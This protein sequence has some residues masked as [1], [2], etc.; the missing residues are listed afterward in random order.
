MVEGIYLL[1]HSD[2]EGPANI[3]CPQYVSIAELVQIDV[4]TSGKTI[5]VRFIKG[6][7]GV[8]AHNFSNGGI[9]PTGWQA[10]YSL[11]DGIGITHPWI[12]KQEERLRGIIT[13]HSS[14][15]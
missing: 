6:P 3:G 5:H 9:Y 11:K 4:E 13:G 15:D 2:L 1:M 14:D 10:K 8:Q 12:E 7:V